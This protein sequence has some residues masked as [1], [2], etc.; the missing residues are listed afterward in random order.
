MKLNP[1][2][3]LSSFA[4]LAFSFPCPSCGCGIVPQANALC[5]ECRE[6]LRLFKPPYCPGCGA[7]LDNALE[8]CSSCLREEARP[9][10]GAIALFPHRDLGRQLIH[11]FKYRDTPEIART[12]GRLGEEALTA[13]GLCFV[14]IVPVPLHWT[15]KL[16]RGFNQTELFCERLSAETGIPVW[17]GLRRVRRTR[18]QARLSRE[19]R[20][21]NL[22]SAFSLKGENFYLN[23]NILLVDDVLT[24]G[25]TL[26]AAAE[27]LL[28]TGGRTVY[29]MV[30][31]RR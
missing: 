7:T 4:N 13:R 12:L 30:P 31:A 6:K 15:R 2:F 21:K 11:R 5:P 18:Q 20:R 29:I 26:S 17:H 27:V 28:S 9:W 14:C 25:A 3:L 22:L 23:S 16:L 19:Q 24:T 8:L 10:Q 1:G